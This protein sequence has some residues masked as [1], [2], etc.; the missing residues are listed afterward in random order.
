MRCFRGPNLVVLSRAAC[1][2][3]ASIQRE[4][5]TREPREP[6]EGSRG[7]KREIRGKSQRSSLN[8]A[9]MLAS[10]DWG[11]AGE[12]LHVSLTYGSEY[13]KDFEGLAAIKSALTCGVGR[14]C[15]CGI[16][17]LEFQKRGA[18]H[19]HLLVWVPRGRAPETIHWIDR[20]W[21]RASGNDS[22]YACKVTSGSQARGVWYLCM[23]AA[24]R[25]QSPG[26]AVGR[27]WGYINRNALLEAQ[28]FEL[29][30][31]I[32]ERERVWWVRLY[33]RAT[34]I[35]TRNGCGIGWFL[36]RRGQTNVGAWIAERLGVEL[37]ER[38]RGRNPF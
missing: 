33:R 4:R 26:F 27:W 12:C 29:A 20:W 11:K 34:G 15:S 14:H 7:T 8:L 17:V 22:E 28:D 5:F 31:V 30:G 3:V 37:A 25:N 35:R 24:K 19:F 9:R 16:W 18:P 1:P 38:S 32:E 13:P 23:H 36:S 10:L 6:D 2:P 21:R